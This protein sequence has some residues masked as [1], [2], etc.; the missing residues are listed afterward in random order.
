MLFSRFKD[1]GLSSIF[2]L[3][4]AGIIVLVF[5]ASVA[6]LIDHYYYQKWTFPPLNILL[7]N[8]LGGTGDELY[9][10][11]SVTY[12]LK[13]LLLNTALGAP[14]SFLTIVVLIVQ[15]FTAV[16]EVSNHDIT[17][18]VMVLLWLGILFS[19]PHKV[20]FFAFDNIS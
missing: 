10:V 2:K 15:L 6:A 16:A 7:Y 19:R 13:A 1:D 5:T 11:E 20:T 3:I 8:A 4:L 18:T 9:G 12:Y 14:L 17:L